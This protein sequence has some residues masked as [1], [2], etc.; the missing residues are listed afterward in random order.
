MQKEKVAMPKI[1]LFRTRY[2]KGTIASMSIA[3]IFAIIQCVILQIVL[4]NLAKLSA[5]QVLYAFE[6]DTPDRIGDW[7]PA[8][9]SQVGNR[10]GPLLIENA[11]GST[12]FGSAAVSLPTDKGSSSTLQLPGTASLGSSFTLA[13][14]AK[15]TVGDFSRLFSSYDGGTVGP[16]ELVF[17]FDPSGG[18]GFGVRAIV[19]GVTIKR[20]VGFTDSDYHQLAMTYDNGAVQL[21]L[22][23]TALGPQENVGAGSVILKRDLRFGEDYPPTSLSNEA[24]QGLADDI[25]VYDRALSATEIASLYSEGAV[26]TLG[27]IEPPPV[28]PPGPIQVGHSI[29]MFVDRSLIDKSSGTQQTLHPPQPQEICL[30]LNETY[31]TPISTY[32]VAVRD[33]SNKVRMY[34]RGEVDGQQATLMAISNDGI[35]FTKRSLGVYEHN[36]SKANN[37][38][39]TGPLS[40]NLAPFLDPNPKA[41]PDTKWK[42]LGGEG[43]L[44]ALKSND[45]LHWELMQT[46]PLDI[47]GAFDSLNTVLW[48]EK[49]QIYR[50]FVRYWGNGIRAIEMTTSSDF[51]N[52]TEPQHFLYDQPLEHFYTNAIVQVP[53]AEQ[54][55]VGFPMRLDPTRTNLPSPDQ[56]GVTDALFMTSHD[57]IH[58]DRTFSEPWIPEGHDTT[59]S[60][61]PAWGIIQT[62]PEEWTLYSNERYRLPENRL[63]RYTMRP[64]GFASVSSNDNQTGWFTTPPLIFQGDELY[65]NYATETGGSIQIEIRDA[66]GK[67]IPGFQLKDMQ[68]LQGDKLWGKVN[69][70]SNH[71]LSELVG[72]EVRLYFKLKDAS[73]F[74][75]QFAYAADFDSDGKVN[76]A[77]LH[78]R[79]TNFGENCGRARERRR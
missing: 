55:F 6:N 8:D 20:Q 7:L 75:M 71:S 59:R 57:G 46:D 17:D 4:N 40:H 14:I 41:S 10:S 45:G 32:F 34:Y 13:A 2:S 9:G 79:K 42:A 58:W 76:G 27:G 11:P 12:A 66:D 53:G 48:D 74:A 15:E 62:S 47:P 65:L 22:D 38:I 39:M 43:Q 78:I 5:A 50:A 56:S 61:M 69:W 21:Y 18:A 23:G 72:R 1:F 70:T 77:D 63:R 54:M 30:Q 64:Y 44:F 51:V 28:P 26:K 33:E 73:L 35:N 24:F 37:I 31:E 3:I 67:P 49:A 16:D 36:G 68:Y 52:W 25:L 19:N 29:Q 60:N